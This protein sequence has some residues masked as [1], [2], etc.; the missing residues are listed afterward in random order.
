MSALPPKADILT[1][2]QRLGFGLHEPHEL[3]AVDFAD[4]D[5][6]RPLGGCDGAVERLPARCSLLFLVTVRRVLSIKLLAHELEIA[7]PDGGAV[8]VWLAVVAVVSQDCH[9]Y[10]AQAAQR[11]R[12]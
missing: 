3:H 2:G 5:R 6:A 11:F 1:S 9:E 4:G 7:R 12:P 8:R 10:L